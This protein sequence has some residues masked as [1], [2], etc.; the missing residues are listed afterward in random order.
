MGSGLPRPIF[1]VQ[2]GPVDA[3]VEHG[4]LKEPRGVRP[5]HRSAAGEGSAEEN[6]LLQKGGNECSERSGRADGILKGRVAR[7]EGFP[8][9][10]DRETPS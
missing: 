4:T 2:E 8:G 9:G 1:V 3:V 7:D 6:D 5:R 10:R